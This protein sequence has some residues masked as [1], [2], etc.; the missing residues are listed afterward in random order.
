MQRLMR[1]VRIVLVSAALLVPVVLS[2]PAAAQQ[3]SADQELYDEADGRLRGY[4]A[5]GVILPESGVLLTYLALLAL[6]L[7]AIGV[8]FKSA[9]RTH[10]D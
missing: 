7:V 8:M 2:A 5:Q 3:Q 10:L 1:L 9:S 6:A 4:D